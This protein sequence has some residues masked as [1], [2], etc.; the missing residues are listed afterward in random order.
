MQ[1]QQCD[2]NLLSRSKN[3]DYLF[4]HS[5]TSVLVP[6]IVKCICIQFSKFDLDAIHS[7]DLCQPVLCATWLYATDF[8]SNQQSLDIF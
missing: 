8:E 5:T 6:N 4:W 7:S 1:M 2:K 3:V